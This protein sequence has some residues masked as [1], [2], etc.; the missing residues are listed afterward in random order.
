MN[1]KA[2]AGLVALLGAVSTLIT[3]IAG[4]GGISNL[5]ATLRS[6]DPKSTIPS[7]SPTQSLPTN[8]PDSRGNEI[9]IQG[10]G[11]QLRN[12]SGNNNAYTEGNC[13][14]N[15]ATGT[16]AM[17]LCILP[18]QSL[19]SVL[20]LPSNLLFPSKPVKLEA[21]VRNLQRGSNS[22]TLLLTNMTPDQSVEIS[23]TS[24]AI[25]DDQGNTYELDTWI[26]HKIGLKKVVP[27]NSR[28][29]L[30]YTLAN[31]I[32]QD[33]TSVTFTLDN[34][35]ATP[36]GSQYSDKLAFTSWSTRL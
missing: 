33:A 10:D 12:I 7:P 28:I 1:Y 23:T 22:F 6:N 35:W 29:K 3:A 13:N 25:S 19:P 15:S 11:N 17:I 34:I 36:T 4:T 20:N 27:P 14:G 8:S 2:V 16:G 5:I 32:A 26:G 21:S 9:N 30:K 31:P 24:L 18:S